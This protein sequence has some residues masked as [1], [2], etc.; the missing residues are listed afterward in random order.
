LKAVGYNIESKQVEL[1]DVPQPQL[2]QEINSGLSKYGIIR[3]VLVKIKAVGICGSELHILHG[4]RDNMLLQRMKD[5]GISWMPLGHEAAG[6]VVEVAEGVSSLKIGD[7]VAIEPRV[8]CGQC[9]QCRSG[10]YIHCT[11]GTYLSGSMAEYVSH[12]ESRLFKI[13]DSIL[14]EE[15]ALIEPLAI[16]HRAVRRARVQTG[17]VVLITGAG[18]IGLSTLIMA[19]WAG[20][21]YTIITDIVDYRLDMAKK[22]GADMTINPKNENLKEQV[23]NATDK[24]G[25]DVAIDAIASQTSFDQAQLLTTGSGRICLV[26]LLFPQ[27]VTFDDGLKS[28][29]LD[30]LQAWQYHNDYPPIITGMANNKFNATPMITHKLP[31][32]QYK[33]AFELLLKKEDN[34]IKVML[35]P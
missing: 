5:T 12:S 7:R 21:G 29:E 35:I 17:D 19:N 32:E 10:N 8:N 2:P 26:G 24:K 33:K 15:A 9:F 22:L 4:L 6:E 14:Y 13:P 1:R 11:H 20:A 34:A 30:M 18:P 3:D 31:L 27:Q 28:K 16:A 25:V 23:M